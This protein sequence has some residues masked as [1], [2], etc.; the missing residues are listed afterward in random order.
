MKASSSFPSLVAIALASLG[1][2]ISL[3]TAEAQG[4]LGIGQ[5]G[6]EI[7][8][9]QPL[10]MSVHG[11]AGWDSNV[12]T[13]P[14]GQEIDTFFGGGGLSLGYSMAND[15]TRF[16]LNGGLDALYY[17][18]TA[19]G[20]DVFYNTRFTA[21]LGHQISR[22]LSITN[23]GLFAYEIEPDYLIGASAAFRNDQYLYGYNRTAVWFSLTDLLALVSSY[24]I[25]GAWYEDDLLSFREDRLSHY[26]GEQLRYAL[27]RQTSV[28]A[29]Y[30]YGMTRYDQAPLDSDAHYFLAGIDR[31]FSE[32]TSGSF[33]AGAEY[34]DYDRFD[35]F[36]RPYAEA[37]IRH[38]VTEDI[39]VRWMGR[40]GLEN[41]EVFGFR[42]R[43]TYR[44]GVI[45][46]QTVT[47]NL[48][49]NVGVSYLHSE[50]DA[51]GAP[52]RTEDAVLVN[53]GLAYHFNPNF[54][55][56]AG[57]SFATYSSD[58]TEREYDRHRI[59]V[60]AKASF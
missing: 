5:Y 35:A 41:N 20:G 49:T 10:T 43:Y 46:E 47:S 32:Y 26:F 54:E 15:T 36:W 21:N 23:N 60:G 53:A 38:R 42:D 28:R 27:D 30:R 48:T 31:N 44:T 1:H 56:N 3:P 52:D 6:S 7:G 14:S 59:T 34:R 17:D 19:Q 8:K 33:A 4:L 2:L 51:I 55:V 12:N 11:V 37:G 9:A 58:E 13:A 29:E 24:T 25:E 16:D 22:R 18:E 39:T 40:A 57:Y 45:V 50:F